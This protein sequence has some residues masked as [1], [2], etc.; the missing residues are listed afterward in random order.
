MAFYLGGQRVDVPQKPVEP[1][2]VGGTKVTPQLTQSSTPIGASSQSTS[3]YLGSQKVDVPPAIPKKLPDISPTQSGSLKIVEPTPPA[4]VSQSSQA[5]LT[6][7]S[8]TPPI[9]T[10][11]TDIVLLDDGTLPVEV[12]TSLLFEDIGGQELLN[13][14]RSDIVNGQKITYSPIKNLSVIQQQFNSNN[15]I[16]LNGTTDKY[17]SGFSIKLDD[18]TPTVGNGSSGEYVYIDSAT[19]DLIVEAINL[20]SDERIEIEIIQNG[21]IYDTQLGQIL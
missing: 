7:A 4:I 9:K 21:T 8:K 19:G 14:S 18:K 16:S 2:Y 12:M 6:V 20:Q 3:F 11:T 17:F 1:F 13:I 10:A 5:N 15:I